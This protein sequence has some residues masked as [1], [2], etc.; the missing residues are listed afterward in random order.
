MLTLLTV[1]FV[2]H[3]KLAEPA[4]FQV[5]DFTGGPQKEAPCGGEG[6]A[7]NAYTVVEAGSQ[8][9]VSW[10][11]TIYHP[12]HFRLSI[13]KSADEFVTP[14][15]VLNNNGNNCASAPVEASPQYPTI[16]DG[17]FASHTSGQDWTTTITVPNEPCERCTLQLLQFMSDHAPP[18]YYYQC[19]T[20]KIVEPG[21]GEEFGVHYDGPKPEGCGCSGASAFALLLPLVL[22]RRRVS[23]RF[24]AERPRVS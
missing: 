17:L 6:E 10:T 1:A 14:T 20:L 5:A 24:S 15:A 13:A 9:T 8:L 21:S 2:A 11:E 16:V 23:S 18:C 22:L 19:A 7:T 3:I 12:G 4:S